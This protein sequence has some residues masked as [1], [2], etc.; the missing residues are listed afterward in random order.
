MK[1]SLAFLCVLGIAFSSTSV[2]LV[3]GMLPTIAAYIWDRSKDKMTAF[4]VGAM[5]LAGCFPFLLELWLTE[6]HDINTAFGKFEEIRTW[7]VIYLAAMIGWMIDWAMTGIIASIM[8]Q[9]GQYRMQDIR[10]IKEKLI[11][12][13]GPEVT[14]Q[15]PLDEFG[16]PVDQEAAKAMAQAHEEAKTAKSR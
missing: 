1:I 2:V 13:W 14:G 12:R 6:G 9:K 3:L 15:I 16:Y 4:T 7:I 5:N 10:K 11:E 8:V